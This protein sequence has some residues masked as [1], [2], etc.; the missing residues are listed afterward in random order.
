MIWEQ[1]MPQ[2]SKGGKWILGWVIVGRNREIKIPPEAFR[3]YGFKPGEE[4]VFTCGSQS[5]GGFGLG[6]HEIFQH[7]EHL[8]KRIF[9]KGIIGENKIV[10][11]PSAVRVRPGDRLLTGR[12]SG[13]ALGFFQKGFIY[14]EALKHPEID[15]YIINEDSG[16][17]FSN[18]RI[19]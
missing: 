6:R 17:P 2:L 15:T 3:E 9:A 10:F 18:E 5:S 19:E 14:D 1:E 12:G 16:V 4:V 7:K 8:Q 11:L 13:W